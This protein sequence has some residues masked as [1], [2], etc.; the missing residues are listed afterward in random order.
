[1]RLKSIVLWGGILAALGLF[2]FVAF[3]ST[4]TRGIDVGEPVDGLRLTTLSGDVVDPGAWRGKGVVLRF[5]SSSCTTCPQDGPLLERWQQD[6]GDQ[7]LVLAVQVGDTATTARAALMGA[8]S[9]VPVLLD[10]DGAAARQLGLKQVPAVYFITARGTLS[11]VSNVEVARTDMAGHAR[12]MLAGGPTIESEVRSVS[13]QLQCQECQGRS[14]WESDS[15]SSF[16]MREQ[17]RNRLL[18]GERPAEILQAIADEYG[19]WI[20]MSPPVSGVASLAWLLPIGAT[21]VGGG[22]WA[23]MLRRAR[24][25]LPKAEAKDDDTAALEE[26]R[27]RL[28]RRIDEYM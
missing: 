5:S 24:R 14:A 2:L 27:A 10:T 6:L 7:I 8:N 11:S 28:K 23:L 4:V 20:L 21:L 3:Q 25:R 12:L 9:G 16:D 26:K 1:M 17:V 22:A 15:R 18:E 19:E 13:Q